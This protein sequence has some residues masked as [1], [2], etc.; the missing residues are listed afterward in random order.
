MAIFATVRLNPLSEKMSAMHT[1]SRQLIST[2]STI[3][4]Y[5][6]LLC[7]YQRISVCSRV[8]KSVGMLIYDHVSSFFFREETHFVMT[9]LPFSSSCIIPRSIFHPWCFCFSSGSYCKSHKSQQ[10]PDCSV[11]YSRNQFDIYSAV[12]LRSFDHSSDSLISQVRY[13]LYTRVSFSFVCLSPPR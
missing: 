6:V 8:S 12:G 3:V 9:G 13:E 2:S 7:C 1:S 10:R 11:Q 4:Y 5:R